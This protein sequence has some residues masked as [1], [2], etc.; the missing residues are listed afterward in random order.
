MTYQLEC[1]GCG[2]AFEAGTP[3]ARWCSARCKKRV[4][5]ARWRS[6]VTPV[7]GELSSRDGG[8]G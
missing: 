7:A 8:V 2:E 5:R 6:E 4:Q 1:R 3:C